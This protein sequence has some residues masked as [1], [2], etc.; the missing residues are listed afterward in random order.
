VTFG[1]NPVLVYIEKE[2]EARGIGP[3]PA[4]LQISVHT[5]ARPHNHYTQNGDMYPIFGYKFSKSSRMP[6]GL[7]K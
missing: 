4:I 5:S 1:L 3:H 6:G 7:L 2:V